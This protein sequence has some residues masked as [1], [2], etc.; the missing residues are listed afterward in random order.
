M[1]PTGGPEG[2]LAGVARWVDNRDLVP[3]ER[4]ST[5]VMP[6][7]HL[8]A[9]SACTMKFSRAYSHRTIVGGIGH[10]L[11]QEAPEAS[12]EAILQGGGRGT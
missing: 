10:N 1:P 2:T 12:A 9:A 6:V 11:P 7:A 3:G 4:S 5:R 8:S